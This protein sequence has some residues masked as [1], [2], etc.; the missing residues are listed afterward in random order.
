VSAL[1]FSRDER[2][3]VTGGGD[4]QVRIFDLRDRKDVASIAREEDVESVDFSPDGRFVAIGGRNSTWIFE[5][6]GSEE[7]GKLEDEGPLVRFS[8]DG[9]TLATSNSDG[10]RLYSNIGPAPKV[11]VEHD[12]QVYA[13]AVS[14]DQRCIAT[15][16]DGA[17]KIS[18]WQGHIVA[19]STLL[20]LDFSEVALSTDCDYVA[21]AVGGGQTRA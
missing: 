10:A 18:D 11:R 7:I 19:Q 12:F 20:D 14:Q 1:A 9:L 6:S 15:T 2:Y 4:K 8:P 21:A 16:S 5:T 13:Y 17:L 3:L